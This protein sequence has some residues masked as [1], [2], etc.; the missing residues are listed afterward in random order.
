MNIPRDEEPTLDAIDAV[1]WSALPNPTGDHWD[2]PRGV[3]D[4]LRRLA[5]STTANETGDAA[6]S[7]AGRGFVCGHAAMV[8]PAA[9]A[10]TPILLDLVASGRR[11]RIKDVAVGLLSD[12][13]G[14]DPPAGHSRV[15]TD[16]GAGIPLCC[17]IAQRIRDRRDVLLAHGRGGKRLLGETEPHWRLTIEEAECRPDGG[18]TALALLDGAPFATPAEAEVHT[19]EGVLSDANVWVDALTVDTSG[20]A[21]VQLRATPAELL[22]GSV[23]YPAEC[24]LREH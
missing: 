16:Y 13:L 18:R 19:P 20:A 24:G 7:L 2:D 10:A 12:A 6:A 4:A 22:P 1:D 14:C 3:A 11:P 9:H 21:A 23:L 17:A 15:D 8:F 5:V